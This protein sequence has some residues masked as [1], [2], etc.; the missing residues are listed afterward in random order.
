MKSFKTGTAKTAA[1][2]CP[3]SIES[4][5]GQLRKPCLLANKG[6]FLSI[7]SQRIAAPFSPSSA[8]V[9]QLLSL[10]PQPAKGR[11]HRAVVHTNLKRIGGGGATRRRPFVATQSRARAGAAFTAGPATAGPR[12]ATVGPGPRAATARGRRL[13]HHCR[14]F[15]AGTCR[16]GPGGGLGRA[17]EGGSRGGWRR[18]PTRVAVEAVRV[19]SLPGRPRAGFVAAGGGS[20]DFIA[21]VAG[22]SCGRDVCS[23]SMQP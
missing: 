16:A 19:G 20:Q 7:L 1:N 11:D 23:R 12:A 5:R 15:A 6:S 10:H 4:D 13:P 3:H 9:S 21:A 8:S 17:Q 18:S 2:L 14:V 22:L